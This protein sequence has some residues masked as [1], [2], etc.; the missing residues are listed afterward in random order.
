[1]VKQ[2]D[3]LF[4]PSS[5]KCFPAPLCLQPKVAAAICLNEVDAKVKV[6]S[7]IALMVDWQHIVLYIEHKNNRSLVRASFIIT[8]LCKRFHIGDRWDM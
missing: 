7:L 3:F 6:L 8:S 1:M 5:S 4:K 2:W